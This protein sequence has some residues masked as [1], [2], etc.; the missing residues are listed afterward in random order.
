MSPILARI[1]FIATK[2]QR[3]A[4][5]ILGVTSSIWLII[6]TFSRWR[7]RTTTLGQ[8]GE[9]GLWIAGVIGPW[10]LAI[11]CAAAII[12]ANWERVLRTLRPANFEVRPL[13]ANSPSVFP[14]VPE[15]EFVAKLGIKNVS[16]KPLRACSVRLLD[17]LPIRFGHVC[18]SPGQWPSIN[19][20]RGE[21]FLLRWSYNEH[22]RD[23]GRFL[24][25]AS[26]GAER[27]A[28]VIGIDTENRMA[29]FCAAN[30]DD[31]SNRL[32]GIGGPNWWQLRICISDE[33][34]ASIHVIL[35]AG[36][37]DDPGP[38]T[39]AEWLPRGEKIL[40]IQKEEIAQNKCNRDS[41]R[42]AQGELSAPEPTQ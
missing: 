1:R 41:K 36:C 8:F 22:S 15:R 40:A 39:L 13:H 37:G 18:T 42:A 31:V 24:D 17:A 3:I 33:E 12:L 34:G 19:S 9:W 2:H 7:S 10:V 26:D 30:P 14:G 4:L 28:D 11:P 27:F 25:I 32:K 38:I 35:L 5:W 29:A 20:E 6:D 16:G 21:S 23:N